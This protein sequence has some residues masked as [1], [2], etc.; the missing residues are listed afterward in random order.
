[1][2]RGW[3][4]VWDAESREKVIEITFKK[5]VNSVDVSSDGSK[6]AIA[7]DDKIA[8]VRTL[9]DGKLCWGKKDCNF[10]SAKFS[11]DGSLL[12]VGVEY[13]GR[14]P[15]VQS[16][17]IYNSQNGEALSGARISARSI[18]WASDSKQLF[19]L[20]SDGN[21]HCLDAYSRETLSKWPIHS[22]GNPRFISLSSNGAFIAASTNA[23]VSFWDTSTRKQI[24]FVIHLDSVNSM[25]ISPNY[26]L[27]ITGN[28]IISLW[29]LLSVLSTPS[30]QVSEYSILG[31]YSQPTSLTTTEADHGLSNL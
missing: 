27:V 21:I 30:N 20:S 28:S 26:D 14:N 29:D 10:H 4:F 31:L 9:P 5:A 1:M 25:A 13:E 23:S 11:P 6:F 22:N 19:V 12:A 18:A 2:D 3:V 15:S 8:E 7:T 16:L 24:G 17:S